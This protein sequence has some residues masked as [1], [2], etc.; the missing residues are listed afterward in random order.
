MSDLWSRQRA[1]ILDEKFYNQAFIHTRAVCVEYKP[2]Q[3]KPNRGREQ[4]AAES[5]LTG[6]FLRSAK[7]CGSGGRHWLV[8]QCGREV[9]PPPSEAA[10]P[11]PEGS[12]PSPPWPRLSTQAHLGRR[13]HRKPLS[14]LAL[15]ER[16]RDARCDE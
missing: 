12:V 14:T 4:K 2:S 6:V 15:S 16:A 10:V 9:V 1:A 3:N 8:S 5:I 7:N 13:A 11:P